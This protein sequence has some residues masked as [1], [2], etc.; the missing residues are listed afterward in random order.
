MTQL[1]IWN[2][3]KCVYTFV[4]WFAVD[5]VTNKLL[6]QPSNTWAIPGRKKASTSAVKKWAKQEG[7]IVREREYKVLT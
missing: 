1:D 5:P 7:F 2:S 6:N 3:N 4:P